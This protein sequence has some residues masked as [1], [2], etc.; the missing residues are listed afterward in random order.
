MLFGSS[1][2]SVPS[3][4]LWN[5]YLDYVRRIFPLIPDPQG[6]NRT[7]VTQSFDAVLDAVGIDP[8]A[9]KLWN[10]YISF[11]KSGPGVVGGSG[12]QDQQ[13]SDQVR[14]AYQRAVKVPMD[15]DTLQRLW[16]EY[17]QFEM[18]NASNKAQARKTIQEMSPHYMSA[19][20]ARIKFDEFAAWIDRKSLPVLPPVHAYE[21]ED[22]FGDQVEKWKLW[23]EWEK[24]DPVD[25]R[26]DEMPL[27]RKRVL[28][29]LRQATMQLRFYPQAWFDAA[30]WC[31]ETAAVTPEPNVADE[32]TTQG[33]TF[34]DEGVKA[35]P[36]SVL[37]CLKKADKIET[38]QLNL[39]SSD[40]DTVVANGEKLDPPFEV[41][42]GALYDLRIKVKDRQKKASAAVREHFASLPPEEEPEEPQ[43][44]DDDDDDADTPSSEKPKSRQEQ[45]AFQIK[46]LEK[47][48]DARLE[49]VKKTI[50]YVWVA[51]M[52]AFRRVQGQGNPSTKRPKGFRGV[53]AEA[54]PRG[55]LTSEVYVASALTEW[56][57][58]HDPSALKIFERGLR[59]FPA[60]ESFA[61][62]Y[63]RFLVEQK[64][65]L[66]NARVVFETTITK[67][68]GP[69][70]AVAAAV[71]K[72]KEQE[73]EDQKKKE[74]VR[75]LLWYMHDFESKYGDL[76]QIQK[77]EK[78]MKELYPD[79]P[80][81]DR[82]A[83][84]FM[85]PHFDGMSVQLVLS[86]SQVRPPTTSLPAVVQQAPPAGAPPMI[87]G[88]PPAGQATGSPQAGALALGP[89]GPYVASPKRPL[90]DIDSDTE[91]QRK[92]ARAE[93]PLKGA[94]GRRVTGS[95]NN[96]PVL[97][98]LAQGP[99]ISGG[100]GFV[101]KNYVPPGAPQSAQPPMLPKDV[102][103][104]LSIIPN[105]AA[106]RATGGP[107]FDANGIAHLLRQTNV[108][109]ARGRAMAMAMGG[110]QGR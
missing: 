38:T 58:Y 68:L 31:Y 9:G 92:F 42:L 95:N 99:A 66:V 50:S 83:G 27:Y 108:E 48:Y 2:P 97:G 60:D 62:A 15:L 20:S 5:M 30:Q 91:H 63:V 100:S 40:E 59:L 36:E 49:E 54:R 44:A 88:L 52:R 13:K 104:V 73:D 67:I 93:S 86:E 75:P 79:E 33:D 14:K 6:Q 18:A 41:C 47:I 81:V 102:N 82:F 65:D 16:K 87:P 77:L 19:R 106:Y 43:Q 61:E 105:A 51:K 80:E 109:S 24:K 11:V 45:M 110:Y 25:L 23:I 70:Q 46:A 1:L 22:A 26:G 37:L 8:D 28:Y 96:Q 78:R 69:Q 98:S 12:W 72:D 4:D 21:G 74:R 57:C 53:F 71:A 85:A 17:D 103:Y 107:I 90:D 10:E 35:N 39:G 7:I 32:L 3:V 94:A 89:H 56:F 84:R 76:A 55:Q 101:T 29:A 64:G 34:L